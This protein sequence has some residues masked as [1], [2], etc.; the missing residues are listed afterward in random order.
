MSKRK[1]PVTDRQRGTE[2]SGGR[3]RYLRWLCNPLVWRTLIALARLI[4]QAIRLLRH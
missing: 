1:W 2:N 3:G 4:D